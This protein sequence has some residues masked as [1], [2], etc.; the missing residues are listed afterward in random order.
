MFQHRQQILGQELG[1]EIINKWLGGIGRTLTNRQADI[2]QK[3]LSHCTLPLFLK[4]IFATVFRWKSYS[5]P[6]DT[7]LFKSVQQSIHALFDRTES[8][9][10]KL[11]VSHALSYI[12][13]A[14][15]G[16]SDSELEDLVS[17][18]AGFSDP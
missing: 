11:L 2:V 8:H 18:M 1:L 14:R 16:L 5:R 9:H 7:V 4:L 12:T 6:Q 15:T 10:G 17:Q 3:A 13:A